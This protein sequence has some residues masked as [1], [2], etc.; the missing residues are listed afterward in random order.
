MLSYINKKTKIFVTKKR[1]VKE[2]CEAI[3][4]MRESLHSKSKENKLK[5][6]I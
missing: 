4:G 5:K 6:N 1:W 3:Y 2:Y